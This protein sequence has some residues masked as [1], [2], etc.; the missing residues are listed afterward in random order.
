MSSNNS[1]QQG[2]RNLQKTGAK[3]LQSPNQITEAQYMPS[4]TMKD[5]SVASTLGADT[6]EC[7]DEDI[8]SR[9]RNSKQMA[10][11]QEYTRYCMYFMRGAA[12]ELT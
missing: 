7:E 10:L 1:N 5:A 6:Y 11:E 2:H 4:Q 9:V 3:E 8:P 12:Q